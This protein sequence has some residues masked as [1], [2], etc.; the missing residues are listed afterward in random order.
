MRCMYIQ[1]N[2]TIWT[3]LGRMGHWSLFAGG[4][5]SEGQWENALTVDFSKTIAVY[6]VKVGLYCKLN[7]YMK[8]LMCLRSMSFFDLG[9]R[10]LR[11]HRRQH[12]FKHHLI[13]NHYANQSQ[14]HVDP[15]WDG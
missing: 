6:D 11:L 4:L 14:I 1:S 7:E 2:Q 9:P 10:S 13:R 8:T 12:F 5:Y 15:P 3:T